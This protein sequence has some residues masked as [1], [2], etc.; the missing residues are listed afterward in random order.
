MRFHV[1][2][3]QLAANNT[4]F[5]QAAENLLRHSLGKVDE[6][7][8]L[9]DVHVPDVPPLEARLIRNRT[10]DIPRLNTVH[11]PDFNTVRLERNVARSTLPRLARGTTLVLFPAAVRMGRAVCSV[12]PIRAVCASFM[13]TDAFRA[14]RAI[15][16]ARA[17][18]ARGTVRVSRRTGAIYTRRAVWPVAARRAVGAT[19]ARFKLVTPRSVL[20]GAATRAPT[21]ISTRFTA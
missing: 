16:L 15:R 2:D 9:V 6:A 18:R 13:L 21:G 4:H 19:V 17:V 14:R 10:N 5:L 20:A 7:V 8:F 3:L 11:V 12:W 1:G